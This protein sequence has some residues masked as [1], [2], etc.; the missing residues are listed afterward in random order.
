MI[1]FTF[2][3]WSVVA[4]N[5]VAQSALDGFSPNPNSAIYAAAIQPDGKIIIGGEFTTLS[6]NGGP[7][8]NRNHI[9]RLNQD[10]TVDSTFDPN[11]NGT[12]WAIALQPDGRI[13]VGGLFHG[14]NSIGGLNRDYIAR[15]DSVTGLADSFDPRPNGGITRIVVQPDGKILVAGSFD[16]LSPNGGAAIQRHFFVRVDSL[17]N[18]DS[19]FDPR[20]DASIWAIAIDGE[21]RILVGGW[22]YSIGGV[23]RNFARLDAVTGSPDSFDAKSN[24]TVYAIAIQPDGKIVVGGDFYSRSGEPSIGGQVRQRLAR[25]DPVTG[26]ADSFNPNASAQVKTV[27]IQADGKILA[28]GFYSQGV[29]IGGQL[30]NGIARLDPVTG[31][32]DSFD[33]NPDYRAVDVIL[34]QP[35]GKI[36]IGGFFSAVSPNGGPA[37]ARSSFA[38]LEMDGQVDQT[39]LNL[40]AVGYA[41]FA[42]AVQPDGKILIGGDFTS[43]LGVSRNNIARLNA[44]GTLDSAFN[45]NANSWVRSIAVQPDGRILVGGT[46]TNVG[47]QSRNRI[48]RLDATTGAADSFDPNA[49]NSVLCLAV[50][51]D[52][53]ILAGGEFSGPNGIGGQTR[54]HIA[55]L[56]PV[57]G[58]ADSFDP[59]ANDLVFSIALQRDGKILVGGFFRG[60]NGIG[61]QARSY[62]ARLD[63]TTGLA[64][65]FDPQANSIVFAIAVQPDGKILAGGDFWVIGGATRNWIAR[66]DPSTGQADSF[67]PN[68]NS[69]VY[70]LALQADGRILAAGYFKNI[71]GQ[72]RN[73]IARLDANTGLA[74]SFDPGADR[75][76]RSIALQP[77]GKI[78]AGGDF[79]NISSQPRSLFARLS[80]GTAAFQDLAVTPSAI[81]WRRGGAGPQFTRV[82]FEFSFD[83]VSYSSLG[84]GTSTGNDWSL[85]GLSLP[86]GQNFFV[87]G[88]GYYGTGHFNGSASIAESVR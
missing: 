78:L 27:V 63:A 33:P 47:G 24:G 79:A 60:S 74:D 2:L 39:L 53:R 6:P 48:A 23:V 52:G 14:Q 41:V 44:D 49:N 54:N 86:T 35:D 69:T 43:I 18:L 16:F 66:L 28:G 10:G 77:D 51:A 25:L 31:L 67:N 21:G 85:T 26:L 64:D 7:P 9:A 62:L 46:F 11:A 55:R 56:D 65:S 81:T 20:A 82:D 70:S 73:Y 30:R 3:L 37:V 75:V 8:V 19:V 59:N 88:R 87:R 83:N 76:V 58:L 36:L 80:N 38:R 29:T 13:L 17:G 84:N 32:A 22:M 45:P 71:G 50:Q 68:A 12:V 57:T 34:Q 4:G 15:L 42:T 40:N 1:C 5:A 61:A 72:A